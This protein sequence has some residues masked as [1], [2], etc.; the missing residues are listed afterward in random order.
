MFALFYLLCHNK[1]FR[2]L[3]RTGHVEEEKNR[4]RERKKRKREGGG[5]ERSS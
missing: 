2:K 5:G 4:R 1:K 3:D